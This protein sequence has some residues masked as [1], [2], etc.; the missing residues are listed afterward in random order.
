M[1]SITFGTVA[2]IHQEAS[3]NDECTKGFIVYA[4]KIIT[5]LMVD[6]CKI[7]KQHWWKILTRNN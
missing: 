7:R 2:S 4:Y 5:A 1:I 6:E 3:M